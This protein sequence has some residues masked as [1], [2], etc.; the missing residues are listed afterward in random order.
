MITSPW[1]E[2]RIVVTDSAI[3]IPFHHLRPSVVRDLLDYAADTGNLA[4]HDALTE[5]AIELG[6]G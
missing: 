4:L 1:P 6:D 5:L 3:I 2:A